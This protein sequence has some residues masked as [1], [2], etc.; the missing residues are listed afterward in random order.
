ML[1]FMSHIRRKLY[2][3]TVNAYKENYSD[4]KTVNI[5]QEC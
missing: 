2:D 3:M 5:Y 1:E 4:V